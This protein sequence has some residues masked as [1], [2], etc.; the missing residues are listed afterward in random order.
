MM[1]LGTAYAMYFN[2]KYQR[3][4]GLFE[5]TFKATHVD[6]DAYF[7]YLFSYIHLNPIKLIEPKWKEVGI[8]DLARAKDYLT[9]YEYSSYRDYTGEARKQQTILEGAS[10]PFEGEGQSEFKTMVEDWLTC[11]DDFILNGAAVIPQPS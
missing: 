2:K 9:K 6:D 11:K 8:K 3:T 1:K 10:F 7:Q 4:G 5:D